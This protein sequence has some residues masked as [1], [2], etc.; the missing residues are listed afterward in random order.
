MTRSCFRSP[1]LIIYYSSEV[2]IMISVF[3][4]RD[5]MNLSFLLPSVVNRCALLGHLDLIRN[6]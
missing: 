4:Q 1:F 3:L 6:G 5:F 2:V